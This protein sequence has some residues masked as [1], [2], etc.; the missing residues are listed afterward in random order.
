MAKSKTKKQR[1]GLPRPESVTGVETFTSGKRV[2]RIIHTN[3]T[4]AYDP[5][6]PPAKKKTAAPRAKQ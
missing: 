3:E 6:P 5:A 4:D 1:T 2:L